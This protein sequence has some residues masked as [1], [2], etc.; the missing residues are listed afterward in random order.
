MIYLILAPPVW[1]KEPE[2]I[3]TIEYKKLVLEC[4]ANGSPNPDIFW[5]TISMIL[6]CIIYKRYTFKISIFIY[7]LTIWKM[8]VYNL[9][10]QLI[11]S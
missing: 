8:Q 2:D 9:S 11:F 10:V 6:I 4:F 7:F 1:V 3:E 5:K